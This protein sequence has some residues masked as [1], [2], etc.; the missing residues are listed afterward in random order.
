MINMSDKE[1][2]TPRNW[3]STGCLIGLVA[4]ILFGATK[5]GFAINAGQVFSSLLWVFL[6]IFCAVYYLFLFYYSL[7][8][9]FSNS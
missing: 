6:A 2:K 7:G 9:R 1:L 4:S 5:A 8:H 3:I